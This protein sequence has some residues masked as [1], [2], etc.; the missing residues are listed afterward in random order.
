[1][2]AAT[3]VFAAGI[4]VGAVRVIYEAKTGQNI[5]PVN[6]SAAEPYLVMSRISRTREGREATPFMVSPPLFRLEGNAKARIRI[7]GNTQ[8]LP[9]DRESLFYL[10]VTGIPSANPLSRNSQSGYMSG[11]VSYA[12]ATSLKL[13]YRPADLPMTEEQAVKGLKVSRSGNG[14]SIQNASPYFITFNGLKIN[15]QPVKFSKTLPDMIAPFGSAT[16]PAGRAYPLS[17]AGK[18][19]WQVLT[20]PGFPVSSGTTLQ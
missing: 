14:V 4:G 19:S 15:G 6:N 16:Y 5:I 2:L 20:G 7:T 17:Q 9:Q 13:F 10:T 3:P 12:F 11:S 8:S 1:M 18:V